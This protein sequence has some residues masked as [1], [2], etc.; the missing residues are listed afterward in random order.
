MPAMSLKGNPLIFVTLTMIAA[1]NA[2]KYENA[3]NVEKAENSE[4]GKVTR[5]HMPQC[6]ATRAPMPRYRVTRPPMPQCKPEC[7]S[8]KI[9]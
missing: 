6:P 4:N 5:S 3:E 8:T 2:E 9:N 1:A 7:L